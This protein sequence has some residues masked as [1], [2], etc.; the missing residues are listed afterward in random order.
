MNDVLCW[1]GC[2][3]PFDALPD[4]EEPQGPVCAACKSPIRKHERSRRVHFDT[5]P[6]GFGGLTG[7]Y[8][9]RCSKPMEQL[10]HVVNLNW[11]G[12]F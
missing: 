1:G 3:M 11:F 8:H 12:K 7:D 10:A 4:G 2:L 6:H 5:D 9:E